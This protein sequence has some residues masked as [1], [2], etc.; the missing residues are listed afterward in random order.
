VAEG[1]AVS[2]VPATALFGVPPGIPAALDVTLEHGDVVVYVD[3]AGHPFAAIVLTLGAALE[4][5]LRLAAGIIDA[6]RR[7]GGK[8]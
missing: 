7:P 6:R 1:P 4:L 5:D 3:L 2:I 8:P